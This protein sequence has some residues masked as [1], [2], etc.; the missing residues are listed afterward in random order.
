MTKIYF[1]LPQG[2]P[3]FFFRGPHKATTQQFKG[4]TSYEM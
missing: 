3:N 4:Q 2:S 1:L